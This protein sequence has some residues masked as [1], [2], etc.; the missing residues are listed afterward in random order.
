[1]STTP[2]KR[3][4]G[5]TLIEL[6]CALS[7]IGLLLT[8]ILT[9][10]S[11]AKDRSI[12]SKVTAQVQKSLISLEYYYNGIGGYPSSKD[13]DGKNKCCISGDRCILADEEF[14]ACTAIF[15]Q[16]TISEGEND[17]IDEKKLLAA[18][19]QY[20]SKE[21]SPIVIYNNKQYSGVVYHCENE[22]ELVVNSGFFICADGDATLSGVFA[23]SGPYSVVVGQEIITGTPGSAGS[24][25]PPVNEDI[26]NPYLPPDAPPTPYSGCMDPEATN[27][28]A[29]ASSD[30]GNCSYGTVVSGCTNATASNY[31]SN[32]TE[33][34]VPSNCIFGAQLTASCSGTQNVN[35]ITWTATTGGGS[36]TKTYSW[37]VYQIVNGS[38]DYTSGGSGNPLVWPYTTN[39]TKYAEVTVTDG[40]GTS[41]IANCSSSFTY[42]TPA[43]AY[44]VSISPSGTVTAGATITATYSGSP[45]STSDSIAVYPDGSVSN[46]GSLQY[47]SAASG[48][49]TFTAPTTAGT[50]YVRIKRADSTIA[51]SSATFTVPTANPLIA[52]CTAYASGNNV[53]FTWT[54]SGGQ[55]SITGTWNVTDPVSSSNQDYQGYVN[56]FTVLYP[57][58]GTKYGT[59]SVTDGVGGTAQSSCNAYVT[60]NSGGGPG[61]GY[62]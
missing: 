52:Y 15:P 8:I 40:A 36:G 59:V 30:A 12:E 31:N 38:N 18:A 54:T 26:E 61:G 51:A 13:D 11:G 47:I 21:T 3:S 17:W 32:A 16:L 27:Y 23:V 9:S 33:E 55:G 57:T 4:S 19:Y 44:T 22:Y 48:T 24:T 29:G 62:Q 7:I 6:L 46:V 41:V 39:G 53:T 28:D 56:P 10:L 35:N 20:S 45:H 14:K 1:M 60:S 5:F 58:L 37:R 43:T 2:Y 49:K 25:T 42:T 50:Y 34:L